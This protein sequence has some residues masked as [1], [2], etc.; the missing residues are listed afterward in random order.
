VPLFFRLM[1]FLLTLSCLTAMA[2]GG[3]SDPG[4]PSIQARLSI[5]SAELKVAQAKLND[6]HG[7]LHTAKSNIAELEDGPEGEATPVANLICGY[8]DGD[9]VEAAFGL[10]FVDVRFATS[11]ANAGRQS[12]ELS[13]PPCAGFPTGPPVA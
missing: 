12:A 6:H 7:K 4:V 3:P 8:D 10:A 13:H 9:Q 1:L 5:A 2:T 11:S